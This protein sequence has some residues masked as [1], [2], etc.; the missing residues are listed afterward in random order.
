LLMII[1]YFLDGIAQAAEQLTGKA[2]GANWRPAFD[3]A[4]GLSM[5][6]GLIL[7]LTLGLAWYLAGP[8]VIGLMTTNAEVQA[9]ALTYLPIAALCTVTFMPAF[10]Y[11][12][13]LV[14]ATLNTTMRNGMV[15]SLVVFLA[16]ARLLQ[17]VLGNWGLWVAMHAW[18]VARGA[19]Y[20]W[21]LERRRAGLFTAAA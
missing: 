15:V 6:W 2:V 18:F 13:I 10:V 20:W 21:A 12:G 7:T 4:Y 14:G 3:Q 8:L 19:I 17:P 1:A 5:V 11:D 16:T 9:Y